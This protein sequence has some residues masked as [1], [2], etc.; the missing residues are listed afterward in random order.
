[1]SA[2][3][4]DNDLY[5]YQEGHWRLIGTA[6]S[7]VSTLLLDVAAKQLAGGADPAGI[8]LV[9]PSKEAASRLRSGLIDRIR[10]LDFATSTTLVRSAHSLAFALLQQGS[11]RPVRLLPGAEHDAI[12]RELL[13]GHQDYGFGDEVWPPTQRGAIG[14]QGFERALRDFLLRAG[15]RG[16]RPADLIRLG[17]QYHRPLWVAAGK[18]QHEYEQVMELRNAGP[19]G[20]TSVSAAELTSM[21]LAQGIDPEISFH[22]VLVDDAQHL[23]PAGARLVGELVDRAAFSVIAGDPKQ[24]VFHFRGARSHFLLSHPVDR[25]LR[26]HESHRHWPRT[27]QVV[28]SPSALYTEVAAILHGQ[29]THHQVRWQDM[30]VVVRSAAQI[31]EARR[32][33]VAHHIPI[34]LEATDVVLAEQPLARS[35]LVALRSRTTNTIPE[36]LEYLATGP[37]GGADPLTFRVLLRSIRRVSLAAGEETPRRSIEVLRDLV[38][39]QITTDK[40]LE[41]YFDQAG[42][43]LAER[44][45]TIIHRLREVIAAA[46]AP[47]SVEEVLW[48]VW[49]ATGLAGSLQQASL[50]GGLTGS[51]A[52]RDLDAVMALFDAA[53]DFVERRPH[54]GITQFT[55]HILSQTLPTGVRDRRLDA[56]EAVRI[57]TA[58]GAVGREWEQVVIAGVHEEDWPQL[59]VT[60]T[61]FGQ[62]ELIDLV[63]EG[64]IPGTPV[65]HAAT[66]LQQEKNLFHSATTRAR[67]RTHIVVIDAP[68]ADEAFE[69]SRFL[70]DLVPEVPQPD[71]GEE[72]LGLPDDVHLRVP[73]VPVFVAELRRHLGHPSPVIRAQAARQLARLAGAGVAAADPAHWWTVG[74]P[75]TTESLPVRALSPSL[76]ETALAC[77]L[78][79]V[80]G[81]LVATP[82]GEEAMLRGTIIHDF[83][84]QIAR[85]ADEE[86]ALG[87]TVEQLLAVAAV[88]AWKQEA[89]K[90]RWEAILRKLLAWL[91]ASRGQFDL[92]GAEVSADVETPV[93]LRIRGRIDRLEQTPSGVHIVDFKTGKYAPSA[94]QVEEHPQLL[95]YQLLLRHAQ[96]VGGQLRTAEGEGMAIDGASLIYPATD[97]KTATILTQ[98]AKDD[99]TLAAFGEQLAETWEQLRG[100]E[101][102]ATQGEHCTTCTLQAVCPARETGQPTTAPTAP[103]AQQQKGTQS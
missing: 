73:S 25:E 54:A 80:L 69:P 70:A 17:E 99:E 75:S 76:V 37:I 11:T 101:I 15:E 23:D 67:S 38:N 74:G 10:H 47:G 63:D 21:V 1:M 88:P 90:E 60:G 55:E 93:G 85:G 22:T 7:G 78:R 12:I 34:V 89:E 91:G 36:D 58:H 81:G 14:Y 44:E 61:L 2:H 40:D 52:N 84:E 50:R 35:I 96:W 95:T 102:P 49:Q 5:R 68:E 19:E 31:Q 26:L 41:A 59:S 82:R 27:Y 103:T 6:G 9:A 64:I 100:P 28:D 53:G 39:V 32:A 46:S 97:R 30:C 79:A 77:P 66:R 92:L 4:W 57:V 86:Q 18:F 8:L 83:A 56:P 48:G 29:H 71:A 51:Q 3:A 62:E 24:S 87:S 13:Q 98:S 20:M 72:A 42:I 45:R 43:L 65:S 16:L 33:L 94:Q